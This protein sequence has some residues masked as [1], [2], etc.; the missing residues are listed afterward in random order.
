LKA[1]RIID[2]G[3]SEQMLEGR[4]AFIQSMVESEM[5]QSHAPAHLDQALRISELKD[6]FESVRQRLTINDA[7]K[8]I[9]DS[10]DHT[11]RHQQSAAIQAQVSIEIKKLLDLI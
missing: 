5:Q 10:I 7:A 1:F 4:L 2:L 11:I 8:E 6:K 3:R 9:A